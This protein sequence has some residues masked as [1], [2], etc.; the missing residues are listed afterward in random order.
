[1]SSIRKGF[2][3]VLAIMLMFSVSACANNAD[4]NAVNLYETEFAEARENATNDM[5]L[6]V[7]ADDKITETEIKELAFMFTACLRE[8][9]VKYDVDTR[10]Y[11]VNLGEGGTEDDIKECNTNTVGGLQEL[12]QATTVNP[13]K[14]EDDE[15][16]WQCLVRRELIPEDFSLEEYKY[17]WDI[18][19]ESFYFGGSDIATSENG[20]EVQMDVKETKDGYLFTMPEGVGERKEPLYFPGGISV[21]D[22]RVYGCMIDPRPESD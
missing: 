4:N 14:L 17:F 12:Y 6:E 1:M 5:Q 21:D 18:N 7:L 3:F 10:Y 2:A 8:R 16:T 11:G 13:T 15:L 9:G 22:T 19:T 20:Y